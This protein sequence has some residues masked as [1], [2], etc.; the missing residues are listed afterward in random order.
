ML[1]NSIDFLIFF[2]AVTVVY[3]VIPRK[4][5]YIWLLVASYWFYMSWN[6]RY[7]LLMLFSTVITYA[8]GRALGSMQETSGRSGR[9]IDE[10]RDSEADEYPEKRRNS[11]RPRR[12]NS[13][14]GKRKRV[15]FLCAFANL[16]LLCIF[17]YL[18]FILESVEKIL[19]VTG[20][21]GS[22]PR[23][24]LLLP[25]GISFFTFQS[26]S[27]TID[28][29]NGR[30]RPERSFF[31]YALFVSFF[32]QLV[33]G[34]IERSGRL[35]PQIQRLEEIDLWKEEN[36]RNGAMLMAW[37]Y[38]QKLVI[39][40]RASILVKRVFS[41]YTEYGCI[42]IVIALLLFAI[43]LYCDFG[44][45]SNIAR[46]AAGIMGIKL[47]QNFRQPYLARDFKDF[48]R[49]WHISLTS[50][51]TDY[52]YMPLGGSRKGFVRK[53]I[54]ILI[55]FAV[56][57]LWHGAEW[58]YVVW[59]L[60]N[61]MYRFLEDFYEAVGRAVRRIRSADR[62]KK[63]QEDSQHVLS[64]GKETMWSV[65][66]RIRKAVLVFVAYAFSLTFFRADNISDA[67]GML[68][69]AVSAV[70]LHSVLEL[71]YKRWDWAILLIA[72]GI[73]L[74]VDIVH[75]KGISLF[76]WV[77]RQ[78][79]WLRWLLYLGLVWSAILFGI[80]GPKYAAGEFIYFR[81]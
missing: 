51:F 29:Y 40:D 63:R 19:H 17:K 60:L 54:N 66:R 20:F 6:P 62:N 33:A 41:N 42:E 70:S 45:Y 14:W 21:S 26:L 4:F 16:G 35:L 25:V 10:N 72:I 36:I 61:A 53:Y 58:S 38:F 73:L 81:F 59:G 23:I 47:M 18:N 55:V 28:V 52:L 24:D 46:G 31:R 34:P 7:A 57:G 49:R 5:R 8:G 13:N 75:E 68:R 43:Q 9:I 32:P 30:I 15:L 69:Q 37:G 77:D 44:G 67:V 65:S 48:W 74:F 56:S 50:W 3:F 39:A 27:Y 71:G 76:Q 79:T 2:P 1:F 64:K 22:A 80:Y 78:E 11:Q 12:K